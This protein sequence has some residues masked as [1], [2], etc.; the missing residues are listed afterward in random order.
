M[1]EYGI[2]YCG[3]IGVYRDELE[4]DDYLCDQCHA[5]FEA[6]ETVQNIE[7]SLGIVTDMELL[8]EGEENDW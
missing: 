5:D 4:I 2:C 8:D 6:V 7:E 3:A 1:N